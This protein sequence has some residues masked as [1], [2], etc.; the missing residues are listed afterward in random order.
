[1]LQRNKVSALILFILQEHSYV[2]IETILFFR[3]IHYTVVVKSDYNKGGTWAGAVDNLKKP[4]SV[5]FCWNNPKYEGNVELI[6]KG[7]I[8]INDEWDV[9][10]SAYSINHVVAKPKAELEQLS[11]F[12]M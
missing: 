2:G 4:K 7:A 12:A 5:T 8:P 10:F 1:M 11:L 6:N 3:F 9:D